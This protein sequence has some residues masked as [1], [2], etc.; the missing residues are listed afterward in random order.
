MRALAPSLLLAAVLAHSAAAATTFTFEC[1]NNGTVPYTFRGRAV[2]EGTSARYDVTEG[3]HPLFNPRMTVVS[4]DRGAVLMIMDH[5]QKTYFMR[6]TDSM[7]GQ[8]ALWKGP[9][10]SRES[11]HEVL[12]ARE[13]A[14]ATIAGHDTTKYTVRAGYNLAM[15]VEGERLK[16]RVDAVASFWMMEG[17]LD[18]LPYGLHFALKTGFPTIDAEVAKALAGKGIPL[19]EVVSVTRSIADGPTITESFTLEVTEV[20]NEPAEAAVFAPPPGYVYREPSF[21]F[22]SQ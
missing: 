12:V 5:R 14:P 2:V 4:K 18:A 10:K 1:R 15:E 13:D 21:G 19:R 7:T 6:T 16:G 17:S 9:G 11:R 22:R 8:L 20:R 3:S